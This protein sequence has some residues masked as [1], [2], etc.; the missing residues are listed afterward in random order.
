MAQ[1]IQC[2]NCGAVLLEEDLF[3]GECGAPRPA[4]TQPSETEAAVSST[5][6]PP[7]P[8]PPPPE[9]PSSSRETAWRVAVIV[10]GITA[11]IL[12]LMGVAAFLLFG[13][14]ESDVTSPAEDWLYATFCCLLPIAGM[15][16]ILA[17]AALG[18]WWVRLRNG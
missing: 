14:T 10:L 11:A 7:P 6:S 9:A 16:A 4:V 3:C 2:E 1:A 17:I 12:C 15:G 18:I 13:L 8:S 5:T